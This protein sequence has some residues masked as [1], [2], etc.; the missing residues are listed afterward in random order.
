MAHVHRVAEE[1]RA[2]ADDILY[3]EKEQICT[4]SGIFFFNVKVLCGLSCV[5]AGLNVPLI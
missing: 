2:V 3:T 5:I 1:R 4:L